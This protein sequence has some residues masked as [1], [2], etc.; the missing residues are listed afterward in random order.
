MKIKKGDKVVCIK[1][2]IYNALTYKIGNFYNVEIYDSSDETVY[3]T[4]DVHGIWFR[5]KSSTNNYNRDYYYNY[6]YNYF[7]TLAE[8]R[9][10]QIDSIFDEN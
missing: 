8:W 10:R 9:D 1:E 4:D 5:L 3:I 2:I 7:I 6:F